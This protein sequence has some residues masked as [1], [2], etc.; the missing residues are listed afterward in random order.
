MIGKIKGTLTEIDGTSGLI[1]TAGGVFYKVFLPTSLL[2]SSTPRP[3]ELYTYLQV[4]E[5]A[6]V[7]APFVHD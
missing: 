2:A 5:D 7:F 6:L 3:V 1:E 4:R